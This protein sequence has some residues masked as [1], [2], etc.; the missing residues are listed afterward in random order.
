[1]SSDANN[2][3]QIN[4]VD[5]NTPLIK[6]SSENTS[7]NSVSEQV[8]EQVSV[9]DSVHFGDD[10]DDSDE[11]SEEKEE[12]LEELKKK[13]TVVDVD[14]LD[15]DTPIRGQEYCLF[16]FMSPEGLMNCNVR[17]VKFRGAFGT[18]A[19]AEK[20]ARELEKID[21]YF[22]IYIGES[23][24]WLDFNPPVSR[25]EQEKSSNKEHQ[26][27]LDAQ[28]KQRMD[29]MNVLAGK[30]KEMIDK[31]DKGKSE[32]ITESQKAGA[33]SDAVDKQKNKKQEKIEAKQEK[34]EKIYANSRD[35]K[36]EQLK[37]K[38]KKRLEETQNKKT[39]ERMSKED[40]LGKSGKVDEV[41]ESK[42]QTDNTS[43][44][45]DDVNIKSKVVEKAT[46]ELED[47]KR[48]LDEAD[49]NIEKIKQLMAKK[50]AE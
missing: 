20:K 7:N 39:L 34:Q 41:I 29:K 9:Q 17:A 43:A 32:R 12:T 42:P 21:K 16:S 50:R 47:K 27:I 15:E 4:D 18:M 37:A 10:S 11:S 31:K 49:R 40:K 44:K 1:M 48:K 6:E 26:K 45:T 30:H 38:M 2:E 24:K 28:R 8:S 35:A 3:I 22:Q 5:A 36:K 14:H 25:V 33:A 13:Y 19:E 46:T 23:G